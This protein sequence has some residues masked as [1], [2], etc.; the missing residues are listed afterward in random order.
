MKKVTKIE[1]ASISPFELFQSC[2]K[3]IAEPKVTVWIG[4]LSCLKES[5]SI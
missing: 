4:E 1:D 5:L 2:R 3:V